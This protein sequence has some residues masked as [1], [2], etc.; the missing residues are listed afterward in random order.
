[1]LVNI[2]CIVQIGICV[3]IHRCGFL[4]CTFFFLVNGTP[5]LNVT[6]PLIHICTGT[7]REQDTAGGG[8]NLSSLLS[9]SLGVH[10]LSIVHS[11]TLGSIN[12]PFLSYKQYEQNKHPLI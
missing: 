12:T 9:L 4:F 6:E 11:F 7:G 2:V 5:G 1:M 10:I 3:E 8:T